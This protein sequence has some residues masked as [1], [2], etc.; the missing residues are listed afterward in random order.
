MERKILGGLERSCPSFGSQFKC[1]EMRAIDRKASTRM[2]LD[3]KE[4]EIVMA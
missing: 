2:R 1:A 4:I 3:M